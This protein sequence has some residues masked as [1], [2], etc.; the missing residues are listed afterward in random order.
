M[1]PH[2]PDIY[3]QTA[4]ADL[5]QSDQLRTFKE[6]DSRSGK[7]IVYKKKRCLNLSSNDYLGLAVDTDLCRDFYRTVMTDLKEGGQAE[8][9][10]DRFGLGASSSRL[11]TGNSYL[12]ESLE[13]AISKWYG[14]ESSLIFNSGYHANV[15]MI[16]ALAGKNDLVLSD[17]LNHASIIDGIRLGRAACRVY[18]HNDLAHLESLLDEHGKAYEKVWIITESLFSMDGDRADLKALVDL[19]EKYQAYL[20]VDE[21]HSV[22]L[23][24]ASGQG[25]CYEAGLH[26][27]VD[28]VLGTFGKALASHGA[29]AV[30]RPVIHSYLVNNARSLI[31]STALPP[32]AV[33]WNLYIVEQMKYLDSQRKKLQK[34]AGEFRK[35][36][37]DQGLVIAGDSHIIPV[38]TKSNRKTVE[39]SEK[40]FEQG[41]LA[42]PIRPPSVP[43]GNSRIRFSL[44]SDIDAEDLLRLPKLIR[45]H[46]SDAGGQV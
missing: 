30:T 38:I 8:D 15:G 2:H 43:K 22:G 37:A 9:L 34:V 20:Y 6:I 17:S 16:Q 42:F 23:F 45:S 25:L 41:F 35:E 18:H 19:K 31:F 28:V 36:L 5:E 12:Y 4:L 7:Y 27:K 26:H 40:L 3:Y 10:I 46:A 29:Y 13:S 44:T 1:N 33:S 21:A 14:A 32:V 24:G 11:L 39:V